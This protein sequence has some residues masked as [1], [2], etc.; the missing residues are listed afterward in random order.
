MTYPFSTLSSS[1]CGI[2]LTLLWGGGVQG[3]QGAT[4]GTITNPGDMD[5]FKRQQAMVQAGM[6]GLMHSSLLCGFVSSPFALFFVG[7]LFPL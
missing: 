7:F 3:H 1:L 4:A 6:A 2:F 5:A